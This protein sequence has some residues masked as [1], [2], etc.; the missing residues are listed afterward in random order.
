MKKT[1]QK[2][3][4]RIANRIKAEKYYKQIAEITNLVQEYFDSKR[5]QDLKGEQTQILGTV[6]F[7]FDSKPV[8]IDVYAACSPNLF[9]EAAFDNSIAAGL[10]PKLIIN[11]QSFRLKDYIADLITPVITHEFTHY[12]ESLYSPTQQQTFKST[13]YSDGK[14]QGFYNEFITELN[15]NPNYAVNFS[16]LDSLKGKGIDQIAR[17]HVLSFIKTKKFAD[18]ATQYGIVLDKEV[19]GKL[20]KMVQS[21]Y[22]EDMNFYM[23]TGGDL[24]DINRNDPKTK[25]IKDNAQKVYLNSNTEIAGYLNQIIS[26]VEFN[27]QLDVI[28]IDLIRGKKNISME[29]PHILELSKTFNDIKNKLN[30]I[31]IKLIYKEIAK[32]LLDKT[33]KKS[34]K[35]YAKKIGFELTPQEELSYRFIKKLY[36]ENSPKLSYLLKNE[37]W[38]NENKKPLMYLKYHINMWK[39]LN[40]L[41]ESLNKID[42]V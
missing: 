24:F 29:L 30:D 13:E 21:S 7:E 1:R 14:F 5:Y 19:L 10:N 18:L 8:S 32:F 33:Q 11:L 17:Q 4:L 37:N 12:L 2:I 23:T 31:N 38:I 25:Q 9:F 28:L 34:Y 6:S 39:T 26:E 42:V 16:D 41:N 27:E 22:I 3:L 36:D 35:D 40:N 15:K 20:L